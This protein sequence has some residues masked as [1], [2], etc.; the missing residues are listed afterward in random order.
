MWRAAIGLFNSRCSPNSFHEINSIELLWLFYGLLINICTF[1]TTTNCTFS[2]SLLLNWFSFLIIILCTPLLIL[3]YSI[4]ST[5]PAL[6]KTCKYMHGF[7]NL[8]TLFFNS[9]LYVFIMLS[10]LTNVLSYAIVG[11]RAI[12][13]LLFNYCIHLNLIIQTC[14][15]L[16]PL[17]NYFLLMLCGDIESNPGPTPMSQNLSVCYWNLNGIAAHNYTKLSQLLAYNAV[18]NYDVICLGETFL[19]S[20][21]LN[22][23]QL[24]KLPGY[25]L[26]RADCPNNK[27]RVELLCFTRKVFL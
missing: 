10:F 27:K 9:F 12:Q 16:N 14:I 11:H 22:D 17:L 2:L 26:I 4:F 1:L 13:K 19:D 5:Y 24:L 20:S 3:V 21:Y 23:D 6:L 25:Q 15:L 18:Y 7:N 8:K